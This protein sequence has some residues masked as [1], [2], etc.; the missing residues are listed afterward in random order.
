[1]GSK[2]QTS[3][4][5]GKPV[6]PEAIEPEAVES[7]PIEAICSLAEIDA[8]ID[9]AIE[10]GDK[11]AI[12][13]LFVEHDKAEKLEA[14][15][16]SE[17]VKA[18]EAKF[19]QAR[20]DFSA[21]ISDTVDNAIA[22]YEQANGSVADALGDK[23]SAIRVTIAGAKDKNGVEQTNTSTALQ[24]AT[25]KKATSSGERVGNWN[26]GERGNMLGS[27]MSAEQIVAKYGSEDQKATIEAQ[28]TAKAKSAKCYFTAKALLKANNII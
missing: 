18:N 13:K 22:A 25:A 15:K 28:A 2:K 12:R 23:L 20:I 10:A 19:Q 5:N 1:M 8:A 9:A 21:Y 17:Y 3:K 7:K 4:A 16:R 6:E 14:K 24:L 26:A 11:A 27:G